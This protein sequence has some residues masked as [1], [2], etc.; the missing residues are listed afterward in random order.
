[1]TDRVIHPFKQ[2][3]VDLCAVA[4]NDACYPTHG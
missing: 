4:A 1:M 2:F 3:T